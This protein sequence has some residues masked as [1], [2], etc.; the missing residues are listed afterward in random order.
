MTDPMIARANEIIE[1]LFAL[2]EEIANG[3]ALRA[4][5]EDL[6]ARD[7]SVVAGP[8]VDTITIVRAGILRA[9]ISSVLACLDRRDRRGNRASVGQ[10]LSLLQDAQV[11]AVFATESGTAALQRAKCKYEVLLGSDLFKR[12]RRL[13]DAAIAHL[14]IPS[15]PIPAITYETFYHLH[16]AAERLTISLYDEVCGRGKPRFLDHQENL[17]AHAKIFWDTY[18]DGMQQATER[19]GAQNR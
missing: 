2:D 17:I 16:D 1:R 13:R 3:R 18:F 15:D 9:F 4:L 10:T 6:H 14:L 12:G 5:L 19:L 8:H 7:L 11:V